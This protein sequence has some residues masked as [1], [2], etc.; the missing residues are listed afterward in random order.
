M[1]PCRLRPQARQD[2]RDEVA[3]YRQHAGA[4]AATRLVDALQQAQTQ[5]QNNPAI[6]SPLLGQM[7]GIDGMRS[8]SIHGFPLAYWYFERGTHLDLVRLVGHRQDAHR[9]DV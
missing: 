8:W 4:A 9:V 7:L 2:R 1:K 6:G 5:M 3:Y